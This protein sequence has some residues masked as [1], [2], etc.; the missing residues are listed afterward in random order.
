MGMPP[1]KSWQ[2]F[3]SGY[4]Y[5]ALSWFLEHQYMCTCKLN[6]PFLFENVLQVEKFQLNRIVGRTVPALFS[7]LLDRIDKPMLQSGTVS[8][9]YA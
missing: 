6:F 4:L 5:L 2:H 1:R 3:S 9:G 8:G 7:S